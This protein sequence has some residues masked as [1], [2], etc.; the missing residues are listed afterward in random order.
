M[1]DKPSRSSFTVRWVIQSALGAMLIILLGMHLIVNHWAAPQGLLTHA[2]VVH[3]YDIPGIALMEALFLFVITV[4]CL[5]GLHSMILDLNLR[6]SLVV[7]CTRFLLLVG[8][9]T[10]LYGWWLIRTIA[11]QSTR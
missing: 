3:Y 7:I 8:I 11:L 10:I 5:L 6:P 9:V 2:D 1:E 4:H